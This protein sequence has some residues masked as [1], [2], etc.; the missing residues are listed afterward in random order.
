MGL[1]KSGVVVATAVAL[2]ALAT[3]AGA[4]S[5]PAPAAAVGELQASVAAAAV[6]GGTRFVPMA[7][8]RVLDTRYATGVPG[9]SPVGAGKAIDVSMVGKV[10]DDAVAVVMNVAGTS[11]TADTFVTVW[12]FGIPQPTASNLNFAR[13]E[14]RSNAVVSEIGLDRKIALYNNAGTTHLIADLAGYYTESTT[15]SSPFT[16]VSPVRVLDTREGTGVVGPGKTIE[17][18]FTGKVDPAATAVT[19]NLAGVDATQSTHVTAWPTGSAQPNAASLNLAPRVATPNHVTVALGSDRK[20]SLF[21]NAGSAHL[22][23]D[24]SGYYSPSSTLLFYPFAPVRS[25][26]TRTNND[27]LGGPDSFNLIYDGLAPEVKAFVCNVAGTNTTRDTFVTV[28]PAGQ[29][30]STASNLNLA[31]GQTAPNMVTAGIGVDSEYNLPAVSFYNNSGH[32]D[33]I[34]D[35]SGYFGY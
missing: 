16:T 28:W 22:I 35:I 4:S 18:D 20:I 29:P 14:T 1:F 7:P 5:A 9:T 25:Y 34:V 13:G 33:L 6:E 24:L 26:D 2:S 19:I 3:D 11:P 27:G 8:L 21:N 31:P 23:V 17:V 15:N 12:A 10:P 32:V 30:K